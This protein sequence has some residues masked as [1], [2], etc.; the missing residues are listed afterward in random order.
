MN[1]WVAYRLS[2]TIFF[3]W[4]SVSGLVAGPKEDSKPLLRV[5]PIYR[6]EECEWAI[7]MFIC[8][9]CVKNNERYAQKIYFYKDG[10]LRIS[11]CYTDEKGFYV[12]EQRQ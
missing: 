12:P 11:G 3:F 4:F 7:R 1:Q 2:L 10:P 8:Q 5:F 6:V 9:R